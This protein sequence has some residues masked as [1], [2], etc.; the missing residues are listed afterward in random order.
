MYYEKLDT[1]VLNVI[2]KVPNV[3]W[4]E[5]LNQEI[6]DNLHNYVANKAL[7]VKFQI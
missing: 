6:V 2:L 4:C 3:H 7:L 1:F 5:A